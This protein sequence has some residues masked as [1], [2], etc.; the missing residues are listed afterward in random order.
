M[1]PARILVYFVTWPAVGH[2][3][4][5]LRHS[6]GYA[7]GNPG[8]EVHVLLSSRTAVELTA[9]CPWLTATYTVDPERS[10]PFDP[11]TFA[12]VPH[13]WDYVAFDG[14]VYCHAAPLA[15]TLDRYR[16]HARQHFTAAIATGETGGPA[17]PYRNRAPL[18]LAL[19]QASRARAGELVPP[20]GPHVALVPAG[21][22]DPSR[23][24][25]LAS[26]TRIL[27]RLHDR[28][29]DLTVEL[30][31]KTRGSGGPSTTAFPRDHLD[32]LLGRYPFC[33]DRFDLPLV[34]QL[35]IA[36]R[37]SLL[38][39]P[40]TGLAFA[41][42]A[43]GTPWLAISGG[44]WREFFHVGV[45]FYS[46]LPDPVRY[47]AFDDRAFERL[48]VDRDGS[49]RIVSMCEARIEE[50]LDEIA[51]AAEILVDRRWTFEQCLR[52]HDERWLELYRGRL[53][54]LGAR[55]ARPLFTAA[56]QARSEV[57]S[58][59]RERA[60]RRHAASLWAA[61]LRR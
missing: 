31:G 38:V 60:A 25:S 27:D 24:P 34:D 6:L 13:E 48:L 1:P 58:R 22:G 50:D 61:R 53:L 12:H 16:A 44:R 26:W 47:P 9:L 4:E 49:E 41:I 17:I 43:V 37:C 10:T 46:V 28:F 40:H 39:A 35:A 51:R 56:Q 5:V 57:C 55:W 52:R 29:P 7:L 36:E 32:L 20:G 30:I 42:L 2:A 23:Y 21:D 19:P 33:R 14:R 18:R 54:H 59:R 8:S 45:P 11:A 3:V 15:A